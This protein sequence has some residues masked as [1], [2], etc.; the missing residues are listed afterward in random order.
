MTTRA[1]LS[2]IRNNLTLSK[3]NIS[4]NVIGESQETSQSGQQL[5]S[6]QT[7]RVQLDESSASGLQIPIQAST[8]EKIGVKPY[9]QKQLEDSKSGSPSMYDL[10][11]VHLL[12]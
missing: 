10:V 4:N 11:L 1:T 9:Q 7:L 12:W 2:D 5:G 3:S 8:K 6:A